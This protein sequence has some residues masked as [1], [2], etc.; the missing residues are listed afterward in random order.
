L[1]GPAP[2]EDRVEERVASWPS[3]GLAIRGLPRLVRHFTS[4]YGA[5][6]A[7]DADAPVL[8]ELRPYIGG[9][10][11]GVAGVRTDRHKTTS[12]TTRLGSP[13]D[14]PLSCELQVRGVF[15]RSLVQ[16]VVIEP[17]L[18]VALA[19]TG[20]AL[21]SAAAI[22]VDGGALV[23]LG[24][25][26]SGKSSV[27]LRAWA[28]GHQLLSDDR[29]QVTA[30]GTVTGF[31][32]RFRLYPD[33]E[34]TAPL[35]FRRLGARTRARLRVAGLIRR[36]T[37]GLIG[38][39]VL[40]DPA[41]LGGTS[42][43]RLPLRRVVVIDRSATTTSADTASATSAD[44]P[45]GSAHGRDRV[46]TRLAGVDGEVAW[47]RIEA[48]LREDLRW[49]DGLGADW[50]SLAHATATTQLALLRAAVEH[51]GAQVSLIRV[52]P[53]WTAVEAIPAVARALGLA[54]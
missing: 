23:M 5:P 50:Q 13:A 34:V 48:I 24:S 6:Q 42:P 26:R 30:D 52:P 21:V 49:F 22:A 43:H 33:I 39:P 4:E 51:T 2:S 28:D 16:S 44:D 36:F 46:G 54:R 27:S 1:T 3:I 15:G 41:Q 9:K 37:R 11:E 17:L 32:R 7:P 45:G 12:W 10:Q 31:K 29:I 35:A 8:L 38:L 18:G 25:S 53:A 19:R 40:V 20:V 47:E 14:D